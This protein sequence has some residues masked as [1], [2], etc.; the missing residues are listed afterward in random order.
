MEPVVTPAEMR[1]IDAE[2]ARGGLSEAT[3]VE[4]AGWAVAREARRMMGGTYGRRVVVVAGQGNNGADGRVA[5]RLLARRGVRVDVLDATR[6]TSPLPTVDL[7]VDAA[8][9][10]G[11]RGEW[12]PPPV[13][14]PVL[15]VDIPSGVDGLTGRAHGRPWRADATVTFAAAKPGLYLNEGRELAGHVVV[16]DIGLDLGDVRR[17]VVSSSD[18]A[19]WVPARPSRAHK[20][21]AG[22]LVLAGSAGM[23][24]AAELAA[25][26]ATRTGAGIVH[27][28]SLGGAPTGPVEVVHHALSSD[29]WSDDV[30]ELA[31]RRFRAA[32]IG[33][34]LG[35]AADTCR[36]TRRVVAALDV[37]LVIDGD[38]L[39][40][41]ATDVAALG[42]RGASTVLTPHDGE[43]EALMGH[44]PGADRMAAATDLATRAGAV[45]LLKGSTTIVADPDGRVA[46]MI[47]GDE[48]LA[49]AG[50]GDVLSGVVGALLAHGVPA[51]E[52]A[53]AGAWIHAHAARRLPRHGVVAG[54]VAESVPMV[55]SS[56]D[57]ADEGDRRAT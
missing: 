33:P 8:Y 1:A 25:R 35:R 24:G 51:F 41:V 53:A 21:N 14:S 36:N 42:R 11:F 4:R 29:D 46:L 2:A 50:T 12:S 6:L 9:G 13:Q 52:A 27:L 44:R 26:A 19:S 23:Y 32:V 3:L 45:C 57:V 17:G 30:V 56:F 15:A 39:S 18:V 22:L 7:V 47:D 40:L 5:A 49:T 43:Y 38:G 37:P 10:T 28:A 55:L 31:T 16:A 20:W 48:R 34:G 54:D